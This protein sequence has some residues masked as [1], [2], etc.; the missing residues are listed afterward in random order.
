[1]PAVLCSGS[2]A[3]QLESRVIVTGGGYNERDQV[4]LYTEHGCTGVLYRCMCTGVQVYVYRC[5]V[6]VYVYR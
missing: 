6:Q 3:I 1:M 2:C 5:T 4:T